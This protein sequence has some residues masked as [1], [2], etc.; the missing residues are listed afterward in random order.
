MAETNKNEPRTADA[1]LVEAILTLKKDVDEIKASLG[2]YDKESHKL[3]HDYIKL[4][5][6]RE[7]DRAALRRAIIEK[8]LS[9]LIWSGLVAIGIALWQTYSGHPLPPAGK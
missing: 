2:E 7:K 5:I 6:E 9:S 1:A 4:V 8:T 3:E